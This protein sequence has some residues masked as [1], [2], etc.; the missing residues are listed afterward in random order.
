MY[1]FQVP[2]K[3]WEPEFHDQV[4]RWCWKGLVDQRFLTLLVILDILDKTE[5]MELNFY[6]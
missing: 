3:K 5:Q 6:M 4:I 2:N 1:Q